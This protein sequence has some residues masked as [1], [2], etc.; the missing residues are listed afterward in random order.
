MKSMSNV[1]IHTIIKELNNEL[2][3]ARIDKA[4]QPA[5]DTIRIK[6]RKAG[7]GRKD[8]V[9]Q[10]GV[11]IHLTDYPQ[12]N[13]TI[14]PNFPMLL[15]KHLSGGSITS[16]KQH[17]FDR[18]LEINVQKKEQYTIIVE[19][20]SKGNVI[21][22]DKDKN[23]ISPLKHRQWH[24]R[25]IT[26]HEQYKYPPEKGININNTTPEKL[27]EIIK[28][29]DKDITRTIA[30]NGLGGLYAEEIISYTN[31]DKQK[32]AQDITDEEIIQL[33]NAIKTLLDKIENHPNPQIIIKE[34]DGKPKDKDFVPIDLNKY[35]DYE[36]K[37]F[38]SFNK[39][40]D[41][42]YSK[43]IVKDVESKE[44]K[45]WAKRIGK[46]E[47]R[48][49]MQEDTLEGFYKTI[50][51][52]QHKGDTIY[53]HYNEIQEVIDIILQAREK[54][55]WKEIST[56]IKKAKKDKSVQGL[57][58]IES[59]DKMGVL[60]LKLDDT[61]VQIDPKIG[62]PESTEKYYNK[63]KKAKRKIDGV[64]IAIENTK[65]EIKKLENK[66][67]VAIDE[68]KEKQQHKEKRELKWYEKLRWFISRDGYLVIGGRDANSNE[69]V[70]KH[71][72]KTNDIYFHCDIH[73]AS[74]TIVQNTGDDEIPETTLYDAACFASSFSSAW[75][76][77][78]SSYDAYW[79]NMDQVSKTP[80]SGEFLKKGSFVIRGKKNFI[81]NV[82]VLVGLG[83]VDYDNDKRIMSG[84][85]ECVKRMTDKFVVIKPG[86]TKKE[87]I[88]K[89]I[90]HIIDPDKNFSI[91][92]I[93]RSLPSGKCDIMDIREYNQK[94]ANK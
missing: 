16:I 12:P 90:L 36:K 42:F 34:K 89:E 1:D 81:R 46:Y 52:T 44:E 61:H 67:E 92:D 66:K 37:T 28:Q 49:K 3:D 71:Y 94:Y 70:V 80:Q 84:P 65:N 6:I 22:L 87:R 88:S 63:G 53:A 54:Y 24:D 14:P 69:K 58:M 11:R 18:I 26:S 91:D 40:A 79:V 9:I 19:L 77:G 48:L 27:R 73:G 39:A 57:D 85:V 8:L 21:L 56:I 30:T 23:I 43:K 38:D 31:I 45:I 32:P 10:A 64:N 76:E 33:D 55:S 17:N 13:P 41:E 15:R 29:S 2:V 86:F 75:T 60:N 68:L 47:K 59:I 51:D 20:F 7:E 5:N 93:V 82:P 74:S 35:Q 62:I 78:F 83:I 72:S 4:Y 25:K 50:E